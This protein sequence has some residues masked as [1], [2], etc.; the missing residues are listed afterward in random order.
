MNGQFKK[1]EIP[2]PRVVAFHK[3]IA[4]RA[5][6]SF[7]AL[8][9]GMK[10][11]AERWSSIA[12]LDPPDFGGNW[13][14]LNQDLQSSSF[15]NLIHSGGLGEAFV[16]GPC[17]VRFRKGD[18]RWRQEWCPFLYRSIRLEVQDTGSFRMMPEQ[19]AWESLTDCAGCPREKGILAAQVAR[20]LDSRDPGGRL[21]K[22]SSDQ[23][24]PDDMP[25]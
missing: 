7:F 25:Y 15:R 4:R 13:Q 12:N 17:W 24:D 18:N 14:F 23:P 22:F 19:G 20:R 5:E 2:W 16:G 1:R 3:E 21:G 8:P 6:E 11:A 10:P 9:L